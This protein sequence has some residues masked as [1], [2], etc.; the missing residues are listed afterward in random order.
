MT[1][2]SKL[3]NDVIGTVREIAVLAKYSPNLEQL[4]GSMQSN[5]E[6]DDNDDNFEQATGL[7]KTFCE[8]IETVR[9][10][11]YMNV[12][13]NYESLMKLRDTSL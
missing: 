7:S 2:Q 3:L 1:K 13:T 4:L 10:T 6:C 11:K 5:L 12:F 9:V 8:K